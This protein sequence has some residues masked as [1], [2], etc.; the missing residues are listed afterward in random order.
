MVYQANVT[1]LIQLYII[2]VFISFTLGQ[3]GMVKHWIGIL[4]RGGARTGGRSWRGLLINA[5]GALFTA[6]VLIIVTITKFTH[7]AWLV[8]VIMPILWFLMLGVNRY[9]R[10]VTK[11]LEIDATTRFGAEGDH[12]IV[13]VGR[14]QKPVLKALDYAI[15]ARHDHARGGARLDRREVDGEAREGV[16]RAEHQGAAPR[17][18]V[19]V[20]RHQHAA[21]RSTSRSGARSTAPRW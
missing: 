21:D 5:V 7:G 8:F 13:L 17:D 15:A 14:M 18:R 12:A 1:A 2:G 4:R 10:D 16:G 3:T 9:Y 11:E 20:P 19:A 6:I